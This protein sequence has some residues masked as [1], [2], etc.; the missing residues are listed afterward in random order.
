[1]NPGTSINWASSLAK[2]TST[3][4][5]DL[6]LRLVHGELYSKERLHRYRLI[7]NAQCPRCGEIETLKHKYLECPY[8]KEIW[9]RTLLLTDKL[10]HSIEPTETQEEKIL[11]CTREPNKLALTLH[12][13]IISRIRQLK[14]NEA[15]LLLLPKLFVKKSAE[16][17]LRREKNALIKTEMAELLENY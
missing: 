8:I 11:C 16:W 6:L 13:E 1:M 17:I 15:N 14:D 3:K 5:K 2:V 12:A 7:D 10:R 4:H 9:R